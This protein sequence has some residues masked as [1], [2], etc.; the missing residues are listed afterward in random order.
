MLAV[1]QQIQVIYIYFL[2]NFLECTTCPTS[3]N[4]IASPNGL[5]ECICIPGYEDTT[6]VTICT[7][8]ACHYSC[9]MCTGAANNCKIY[10]FIN[11]CLF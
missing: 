1:G 8:I 3:S 11:I 5:G 6:S 4:R 2:N 9:D 10:F 7:L